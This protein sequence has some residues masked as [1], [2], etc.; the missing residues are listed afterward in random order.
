V[1]KGRYRLNFRLKYD[2]G[3]DRLFSAILVGFTAFIATNL[4]DI[5]I[6]MIFFSQVSLTF[7]RRH[8]IVGQYLGFMALLLASLLGYFGGL[9]LP[10]AWVGLLGFLPI[11]I[12]MSQLLKRQSDKPE[13]KAVSKELTFG[14]KTSMMSVSNSLFSPQTYQVAAV[15]VVNGGD[16]VGIYIPLFASSSLP[17][18]AV[19]VGVFLILV[20]VWCWVAERLTRQQAIA[21]LLTRYGQRAIP[22]VLMSL[23][24][25]ILA[26]SGTLNL[27]RYFLD[28]SL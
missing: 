8:I 19:M 15:T 5:I 24:L 4:D 27:L 13:V 23:G 6:L 7:R 12:G 1:V 18:L 26:D 17:R 2:C 22:F 10:K 25:Y 21:I 11:W 28:R 9:V 20:G 14:H 16:N 3:M